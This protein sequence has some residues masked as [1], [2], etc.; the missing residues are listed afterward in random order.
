MAIR[1]PFGMPV[2]AE[3]PMTARDYFAMPATEERYELIEGRLVV[4]PSPTLDHQDVVLEVAVAFRE[5]QRLH[6]GRVVIAPADVELSFKTVLQP[7]VFYIAPGSIAEARDH[8]IG[9]PDLVVEVA[10]PSTKTY[11]ARDKL[12]VYAMHGVRE[13]WIIDPKKKTV[14]VHTARDGRFVQSATVSFGEAIPS[15]IVAVGDAG[16]SRFA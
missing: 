12:P 8:V 3:H 5:H 7:D 6:G 15:A 14:T 4:M 11:D 9:A 10:S 1:K 16:L 2:I 13:A